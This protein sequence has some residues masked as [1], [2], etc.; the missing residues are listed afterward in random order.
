MNRHLMPQAETMFLT[1]A[2]RHSFISSTLVREVARLGG[3]ITGFV[4]P[5]VAVALSEKFGQ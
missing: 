4:H 3:D 5:L 1:P 2:E